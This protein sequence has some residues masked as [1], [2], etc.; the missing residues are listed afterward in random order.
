MKFDF[1]KSKCFDLGLV[2]K[3]GNSDN[4]VFFFDE[5]EDAACYKLRLFR[6][7]LV[8]NSESF[9]V[10]D[11][12]ISDDIQYRNN[13]DW[14]DL[15][16]NHIEKNQDK[17]CFQKEDLFVQVKRIIRAKN[18]KINGQANY[19]GGYFDYEYS[20]VLKEKFS[21]VKFITT[22]ES[23]RNNLYFNVNFLP[24]GQYLAI[25]D[26]ENRNGEIFKTSI[27]YYFVIKQKSEKDLIDAI[28][29]VGRAAA[30]NCVTI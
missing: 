6:T 10:E 20:D 12:I 19:Y 2:V 1:V 8:A 18:V 27:P 14:F 3:H 24:C 9:I 28:N 21:D 30:G 25:L 29:G 15:N 13:N 22:I 23:D 11:S 4:V 26:I 17:L 7:N 16:S 5:N